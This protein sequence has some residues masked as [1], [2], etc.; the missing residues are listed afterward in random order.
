MSHQNRIECEI[1]HPVSGSGFG[2]R[3]SDSGFRVSG[4]GL[5]VRTRCASRPRGGAVP[6]EGVPRLTPA[7]GF[8]DQESRFRVESRVSDSLSGSVLGSG[9]ASRVQVVQSRRRVS[10]ASHL[11]PVLGFRI[12]NEN[13]HKRHGVARDLIGN[14]FQF[15]TF[16]Q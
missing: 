7:P 11:H 16:W 8:R 15:K 12:L 1:S 5:G 6:T 3:V 13:F 10:H 2:Y 4:C 9:T 14:E